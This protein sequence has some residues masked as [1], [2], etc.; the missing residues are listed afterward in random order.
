MEGLPESGEKRSPFQ[1][2][3]IDVKFG[4]NPSALRKVMDRLDAMLTLVAAV[5]AGS[6]SAGSRKLGI[7]L[8]TVS[9]RVSDLE[10]FLGTRLLL[11]GSRKLTL[12]DA[13]HAYVAS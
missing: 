3:R 2:L 7:P 5:D 13:G 12:T 9:R 10:E 4:R 8:A 11:R 1:I 6:L